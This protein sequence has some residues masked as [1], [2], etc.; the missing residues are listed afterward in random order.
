VLSMQIGSSLAAGEPVLGIACPQAL[1]VLLIQAEDSENDLKRQAK[2]AGVIVPDTVK[3]AALGD[4]FIEYTTYS[5]G[6]ELIQELKEIQESQEE[7]FNM[8]ILNPAFAFLPDGAD[9]NDATDVGKFLRSIWLP[10]LK[11]QEAGGSSCT[12]HPN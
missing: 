9:A 10:F 1:K 8:F 4:K 12:T 6:E 2:C 7:K 5:R 3:Q 11:K